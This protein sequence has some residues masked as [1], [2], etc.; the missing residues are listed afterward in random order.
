MVV[1]VGMAVLAQPQAKPLAHLLKPPTSRLLP[2]APPLSV[3]LGLDPSI[4]A[5]HSA[6][7]AGYVYIVT[8]QKNGTLYIG[9]TSDLERR[10]Y[11]HREG[12]TPGFAWKYGCTR[13]VWY[14]EHWD[15]GSAIQR[16]KSLKRWYRQWKVDL[17]DAMNPG[18]D[19]LYLTLW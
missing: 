18:W 4:H 6:R 2:I 19:D 13:L 16:E 15:I 3:I 1:F 14:E 8:N 7:M 17:V 5:Q 10:I 9:V 12:L 11:E